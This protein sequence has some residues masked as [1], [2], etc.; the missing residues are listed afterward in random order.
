[1]EAKNEIKPDNRKR[2]SHDPVWIRVK[3]LRPRIII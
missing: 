3:R 2:E 1:M